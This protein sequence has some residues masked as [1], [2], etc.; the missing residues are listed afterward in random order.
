MNI[1]KVREIIR[2]YKEHFAY[3][4]QEEIY[5]WQAVKCFQ[6]HWDIDA[7]DF[8]AML[9]ASF[10]NAKNLMDSGNYF[11]KR[12]LLKNAAKNA[13]QI[14]NLFRSLFDEEE[15]II[16]RIETFKQ[17]FN[18]INV[19]YFP[20]ALSYQ[21][22]RAI[23]VYLCLKYP[24]RYYFYK[25]EMFRDFIPL[26]DYP[27]DIKRGATENVTQFISL[28]NL[29][30]AEIIKDNAV[31]ELHKSR[32]TA[33][34]F[35]DSSFNILT[36][37]VIYAAVK[38]I[39]KF[40]SEEKQDSVLDRFILDQKEISA[41]QGSVNLKGRFTNY[42]ENEQ[43]N[44]RLGD[45]GE[46]LVL[47]YEKARLKKAGINKMPEQKSK[48]EGDGIGYDILSYDDSG[49]EKYI[50]VKTTRQ[51]YSSPFFITRNELERSKNDS[52][53]FV[54]YRLFEFDDSHNRSKY[55]IHMGDLSSLCIDPVVYKVKLT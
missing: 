53:K 47:E 44:K 23:V 1:Q 52:D 39:D 45:L 50:E 28:C 13:E 14:R 6:E 54:L 41:K 2:R 20:D 25:H 32:L 3:I 51:A 36:Q 38:H 21:D 24:D 35:F 55:F 48:S 46:L 26:I 49:V 16:L 9:E 11:P 10:E 40:K 22:M 19:R 18:T 8:A 37:D 4:H 30:K 29:I 33:N 34:E 43:E 7:D 27:Y 12:M 15:D 5:K 17:Q 31:L 42:I